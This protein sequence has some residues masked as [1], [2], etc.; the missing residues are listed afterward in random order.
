MPATF[1]ADLEGRTAL[2][3]GSSTGIGRAI[4]DIF[5]ANGAEVIGLQR[6]RPE[7]VS[8][9]YHFAE[10]DLADPESLRGVAEDVLSRHRVDILVNN[11]GTTLR[12]PFEEF[13]LKDWDHVFQVNL[14]SVVELMQVFGRPMLERGSG[15]VINIA[16]MLSFTGGIATAAYSASKGGIAQL[17]KSVANEWAG[18]GVNVNA[19]A[20]GYIDTDLNA[21][22]RADPVRDG[23][24]LARIPAGRW[25]L[26]ADIAGAALFLAS[27]AAS[28]LHGVV[29][30]VDG[31]YLAR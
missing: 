21:P 26:A 25:G 4:A 5:L 22:L 12:H 8:G 18:R 16:S 3:T 6:R 30:P 9:R 27:D 13:P 1:S 31:G 15:K 14:R 24:I 29:L 23:Q 7:G 17:T 20:P 11:A 2:V 28:Y 10:A 19:I